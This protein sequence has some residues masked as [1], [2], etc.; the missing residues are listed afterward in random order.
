VQLKEEHPLLN[1]NKMI[2]K[3]MELMIG[4]M[5]KMVKECDEEAAG[6]SPCSSLDGRLVANKSESS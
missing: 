1:G 2:Q 4:A 5:K 3:I 6:I